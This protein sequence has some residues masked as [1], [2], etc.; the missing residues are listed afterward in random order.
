MDHKE[1]S[2]RMSFA[3]EAMCSDEVEKGMPTATHAFKQHMLVGRGSMSIVYGRMVGRAGKDG[4]THR[5]V[6]LAAV[7][8][9]PHEDT[10]Q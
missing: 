4:E 2:Q 9:W 8:M 10:P 3:A 6:W 1:V 5:A 7:C